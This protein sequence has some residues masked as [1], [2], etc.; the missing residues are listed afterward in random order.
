MLRTSY[1]S[2][3]T[4]S[5]TLLLVFSGCENKDQQP[6]IKSP[7]EVPSTVDLKKT[8]EKNSVA[9]KHLPL[10]TEVD[11]RKKIEQSRFQLSQRD[12][13]AAFEEINFALESAKHDDFAEALGLRALIYF[14]REN[15]PAAVADLNLAIIASTGKLQA[16]HISMRGTFLIEAS[17]TDENPFLLL[18]ALSDHRK[19][20][21]VNKKVEENLIQKVKQLTVMDL[22]N[23]FRTIDDTAL[24]EA[25][26]KADSSTT[27]RISEGFQFLLNEEFQEAEKAFTEELQLN[28]GEEMASV[29]RAVAISC[30]SK[31]YRMILDDLKQAIKSNPELTVAD[32]LL[33]YHRFLPQDEPVPL[34]DTKQQRQKKIQSLALE[35]GFP[36]DAAEKLGVHIDLVLSKWGV[37][38]KHQRIGQIFAGIAHQAPHHDGKMLMP[39][40]VELTNSEPRMRVRQRLNFI[41]GKLAEIGLS[42]PRDK[43]Q[44]S[45]VSTAELLELTKTMRWNRNPRELQ[46]IGKEIRKRSQAEV[47]LVVTAWEQNA[48]EMNPTFPNGPTLFRHLTLEQVVAEL[49]PASVTPLI[50][51]LKNPQTAHVR[52]AVVEILKRH[53]DPRCIEPLRAAIADGLGSEDFR[54]QAVVLLESFKETVPDP[55][56]DPNVLGTIQKIVVSDPY[57]HNFLDFR[58]Y[59][60]GLID[61]GEPVVK[62]LTQEILSML[63]PTKE[64]GIRLHDIGG[65]PARVLAGIGKQKSARRIILEAIDSMLQMLQSKND[66]IALETKWYIVCVLAELTDTIQQQPHPLRSELGQRE[67]FLSQSMR[68]IQN[69]SAQ[70]DAVYRQISSLQ[71]I[72]KTWKP[73]DD[74]FK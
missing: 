26:T 31:G 32:D 60:E 42:D 57:A 1:S 74:P 68:Q 28:P 35:H 38:T 9:L 67:Q 43:P 37:L 44:Y 33:L 62:P 47:N 6:K 48:I 29:G 8:T 16:K 27:P 53:R 5:L 12:F 15:I 23:A 36:P 21:V 20:A 63:V 17:T 49:G 73:S 24:E 3:I 58:R 25:G 13:E 30:S 50:A 51:M 10:Q 64:I 14:G 2:T 52:H 69:R 55:A 45:E 72:W 19:S 46:A 54:E 4:W 71:K 7:D 39:M 22:V 66:K 59:E 41:I 34:P 40:L 56:I 11:V 65:S 18:M 61:V 70:G